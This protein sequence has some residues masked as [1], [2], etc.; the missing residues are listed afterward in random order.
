VAHI[1]QKM[2]IP[3]DPRHKAR[4]KIIKELFG[5]SFQQEIVVKNKTV[6]EII[7]KIKKIDKIIA[8]AAPQWPIEQI[9]RIDLAILRLAIWELLI[10]R[11]EP[12]KV[13]IDE[14]VE[15]AKTYGGEKSPAF[16]NGALGAV[17]K[18]Y[19]NEQA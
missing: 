9:N 2:K 5:W 3:K 15:L 4:E 12:Q 1:N 19:K 13:I 14:A 17:L 8:K 6:K 10:A 11:R 16:I 7:K 18:S